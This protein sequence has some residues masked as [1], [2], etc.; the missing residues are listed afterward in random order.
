MFQS[1]QLPR[2]VRQ[3]SQEFT[4][5]REK[6]SSNEL[7][8]LVKEKSNHKATFFHW[9][10]R[11]TEN[12]SMTGEIDQGTLIALSE[13]NENISIDDKVTIAGSRYIFNE[14]TPIPN[15]VSPQLVKYSLVRI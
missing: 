13:P 14:R 5:T 11:K 2:I 10:V 4:L 1:D 12:Q 3:Q 15:S 7:G 9:N 8:E 6:E